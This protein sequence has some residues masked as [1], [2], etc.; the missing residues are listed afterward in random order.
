M[1][2]LPLNLGALESK[3]PRNVPLG[4]V[5]APTPYPIRMLPDVSAVPT[6]YQNGQPACG[7]HA[8]AWF[9]SYLDFLVLRL[10]IR[11]S[12]RFVYD[13]CKL[14]DGLPNDEGTTLNAIFKAMRVYGVP[15]NSLFP[16]DIHLSKNEYRD[17]SKI[18]QA[19]YADAAANK[20]DGN[21]AIKPSPS[22][23]DVCRTIYQKQAVILLIYCDDG[24]FG[25]NTPT[26]TD[27]EYGHFVVGYGYDPERTYVIDSTEP[28]SAYSYKS[29]P[30][31]AFEKGF[32]RQM[33]TTAN[34]P[35]W[36]LRG[37]TSPN[38]VKR[39]IYQSLLTA[40][41]QLLKGR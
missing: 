14:I 23:A 24:F 18:P 31:S 29:I 20:V 13:I 40:Y 10:G 11:R 37:L 1:P 35:N 19:A 16:N 9:K 15:E 5:Q 4:A 3:D 36:Q 12:P 28:T 21:Y 33:G 6:Y 8:G 30:L 17:A 34:L 22:L 2:N 41:T 7:G 25:T 27:K 26:F 32:V 39:F 38:A